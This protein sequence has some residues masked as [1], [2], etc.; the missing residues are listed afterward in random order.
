MPRFSNHSLSLLATCD[1]KLQDVCNEAIKTI[2]FSIICG[3]RGQEEQDAAVAAGKSHTPWP[4]SNHNLSPSHAV[5]LIPYPFNPLTDWKNIDKFTEI[6]SHMQTAADK[7]G[8]KIRW[9]GHFTTL[10]DYDHWELV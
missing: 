1:Q 5:D 10:K 2:D 9:G 6:N 7:L 4:T 8:I 3:F